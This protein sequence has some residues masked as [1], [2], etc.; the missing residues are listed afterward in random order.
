[1]CD[2][3]SESE[4][5]YGSENRRNSMPEDVKNGVIEK[6]EKESADADGDGGKDVRSKIYIRL[7][8][9]KSDDVQNEGKKGTERGEVEELVGK[10]WNLRPRKPICKLSNANRGV[11]LQE[12]KTSQQMTPNQPYSIRMQTGPEAEVAEKKEKKQKF[13]VS[14]SWLEIEDDVFALTGSKPAKRP[15]KRAKIVQKQ[16]DER[17]FGSINLICFQVCGWLQ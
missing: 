2:S 11:S 14:L 10:S 7:R 8:K 16:H 12:N 15:K 13:S 17:I 1:M 4:S 9:N 5:G 3:A 6:S